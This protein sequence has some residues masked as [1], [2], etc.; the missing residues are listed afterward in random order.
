MPKEIAD[1][2]GYTKGIYVNAS[3]HYNGLMHPFLNM[4]FKAMVFFQGEAEGG[5]NSNPSSSTYAR[6]FEALM[7]E[8][9]NRWGFDFPVYNVQISDYPGEECETNWTHVGEVRS[10]QYDAYKKMTGIRLIPSYDIGSK[11]TD[12]D[13]AHSP[14]KKALADRIVALA[15]ADLY[16]KG[17]EDDA[18][19]P[20][21][22]EI[23]VISSTDEEKVIE[24]KFKNTGSGLVSLSGT[25][26]V[27]GFVYG[28]T[29]HPYGAGS[30][31][32]NGTI[33]SNDTVR[34]IVS[35]GCKYIGYA[36]TQRTMEKDVP[37]A[38]LYNSNDLPALAFDLKIK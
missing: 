6:D 32:V 30:T 4:K 8:L 11:S 13:G 37:T 34:V 33:V 18:L 9:R 3:E 15:L 1:M 2:F 21:P 24:I 22:D 16:N 20:E 17:S 27:S 25:D 36:C 29:V 5:T 14:Y 31:T 7:T 19:A 10:Q 12:P 28:N 38:Q 35:A 26:A 23:N